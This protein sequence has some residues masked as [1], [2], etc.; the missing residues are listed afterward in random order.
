MCTENGHAQDGGDRDL[1][2]K[3]N[4]QV[5]QHVVLPAQSGSTSIEQNGGA[6]IKQNGGGVSSSNYQN[7]ADSG[8][9]KTPLST[10]SEDWKIELG[11]DMNN[12]PG[13]M[14]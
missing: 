11:E 12:V 8:Y 4:V 14:Y 2:G 10:P 6:S 9:P 5:D 13:G 3:L 7:G 1:G